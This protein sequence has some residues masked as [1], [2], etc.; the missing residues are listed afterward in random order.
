MAATKIRAVK[1]HLKRVLEYIQNPEKTA[2][3][4]Y[5]TGINCTPQIACEE[6][7]FTKK[8]WQKEKST[9]AYH[10]I[11]SFSPGEITPQKAHEIGV[12]Y[13]K[14]IWGERFQVV[15]STHIDRQHI[16][17]HFVVNSVSFTDGKRYL[18]KKSTYYGEIRAISDGICRENGLSVI[19]PRGRGMDYSE[20]QANAQGKPTIRGMIR[21]DI[22]EI[23]GL[24][25]TYKSFLNLLE[26][27]GYQIRGGPNR[28]YL[29]V[30]PKGGTRFI[31]LVSLGAEYTEEAIK[32]RLARQRSGEG[33][34]RY[35]TLAV[36]RY[37]V[38]RIPKG[39]KLH[40][41]L[42]LYFRYLYLLGKVKKNRPPARAAILLRADV[43]K[44][45]RYKQAFA[46]LLE[47]NIETIDQLTSCKEALEQD[48][49]CKLHRRKKLYRQR[50]KDETQQAAL[51]EE[52]TALDIQGTR[53]ALRLCAEIAG[54]ASEMAETLQKIYR[55]EAKEV[56]K[57]ER[58]K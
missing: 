46:F 29:A 8:A 56:K 25:Y 23:I 49:N 28:K 12:E 32:E 6:M 20:W 35:K 21:Q 22:D 17:N 30:R 24:S 7:F 34:K 57:D 33:P 18:D 26:N 47:K 13:A 51:S 10:V 36:P 11:Q 48:L 37:Y 50:R 55:Q 42:A 53:R 43:L 40:G 45:N 31:R 54:R 1:N 44:W 27:R 9:L 39:R 19:K 41:F 3:G 14:R 2:Q 58:R 38:K 15:V 5:V 52:I 16:H 4:R